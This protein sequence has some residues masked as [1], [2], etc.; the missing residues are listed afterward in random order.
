MIENMILEHRQ[1]LTWLSTLKEPKCLCLP[2]QMVLGQCEAS[3]E[4]GHQAGTKSLGIRFLELR[5]IA[6]GS[7][8][9]QRK[10]RK[11]DNSLTPFNA[12]FIS[13]GICKPKT[14]GENLY[15]FL[16]RCGFF[17]LHK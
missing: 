4:Q 8:V 3:Q 13:A 12:P 17:F 5:P 14:M 16:P 11:R 1:E 10:P 6:S 2:G 7:G 15:P 9:Q